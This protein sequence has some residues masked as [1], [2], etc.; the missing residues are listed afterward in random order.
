MFDGRDEP[1]EGSFEGSVKCRHRVERYS[2]DKSSLFKRTDTRVL[3][4]S[5][6]VIAE[7]HI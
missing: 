4:T 3:A 2:A 6:V 1:V 5:R 7:N